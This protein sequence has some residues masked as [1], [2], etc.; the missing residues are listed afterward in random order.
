M[1]VSRRAFLARTGAAALGWQL[2]N[3]GV[4]P[5]A[6]VPAANSTR[7]PRPVTRWQ[8]RADKKRRLAANITWLTHE[9]IEFL[10]R[11][12]DRTPDLAGHYRRMCEASN[13]KQMAA[14]GVRWGRI[15]FYKGFGLQFEKAHMDVARRVVDQM[16]GLGM[17]VSLYVGGTMFY[18]TLYKEIPEAAGWEQRDSFNRPVPYGA[19]TF[20]R[21]ACPNEPA[22]RAYI[23]RVLDV[24]VKDFAADEI[25]FDN[26]VLQDEPRSCRCPRCIK[27]FGEFLRQRGSSLDAAALRPWKTPEEPLRLQTIDDRILQE[28]V[29]FRCQS[30]AN[31]A[32]DYYDYVKS[33]NPDTACLL[34]IK[35]VYSYNRYWTAAVYQPMF[36][37]HIDFMAFD[38][39]GYDEH[40][41]ARS[42]ALVSQIRSYKLARRINTSCEDTLETP[43]RAAV[44]M[45]FGMQK[46]GTLPTPWGSGAHNVFT[47]Q[48]EFFR[49][50]NERF[51][52]DTENVRDVAVLHNWPSMAFSVNA[53]AVP[54][55]LMEQV[56]I[57]YKVPFELLF[58][59]QMDRIGNY[60]A[61][62]LA[63]Q[64]CVSYDQQR[65]LLD[66]VRGGGTLVVTGNTG[67]RDQHRLQKGANLLVPTRRE[68]LGRIVYIP[69][70]IPAVAVQPTAH[71]TPAQWVLPK[72][73]AEIYRA[74][75][76]AM[77]AELS[78][79]TDAPLT[80]V[81][82]LLVRQKSRETIAHFIRF[83][84]KTSPPAFAA[85][86]KS[87]FDTPVKSVR[88]YS[89]EADDPA[90]LNFQ[91]SNGR[92]KF[93]VPATQVYAMVVM[94]HA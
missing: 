40:I 11:R 77:P 20:R 6:D 43:V 31:C 56:L 52:T 34:N 84:G 91:E 59:E 80:T 50:Y 64:E 39:G 24:G 16:H 19:Q 57:Q 71:M 74:I 73:H 82:E 41:D 60:K 37:G 32:A 58:D 76:A 23:K 49:E 65:T 83:D 1:N 42:G 13:I 88:C 33:L 85:D 38:T 79:V 67:E 51:Y 48:L 26:F 78:I 93:T 9:P 55:T 86:V 12:G 90:E 61:V 89:A 25:A 28:W 92:V 75:V 3:D 7:S 72:N 87:L 35:G 53:T 63:G 15:F 27:A 17:K 68:G 70:I 8:Q 54:V 66:Y 5:A 44:H 21:F 30:L 69:E 22:Y 10:L 46:P 14:A 2:L 81:M 47:P 36:A 62:I 18:E 4:L 29:R 94:A 45:A